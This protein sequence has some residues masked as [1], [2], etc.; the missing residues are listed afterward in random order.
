MDYLRLFHPF[1]NVFQSYQEEWKGETKG[2]VHE[3]PY[4]VD[5]IPLITVF[6]HYP[7]NRQFGLKFIQ[8]HLQLNYPSRS[9]LVG[10][11]SREWGTPLVM[12]SAAVSK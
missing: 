5:G 4:T 12:C 6:E 11:L 8:I 1:S 10:I 9:P 2:C 7:S 3:T